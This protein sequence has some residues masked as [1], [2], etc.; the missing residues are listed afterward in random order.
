[1]GKNPAQKAKAVA[2]TTKAKEKDAAKKVKASA[3]AEAKPKK[4]AK[5]P[6]E[7]SHA[8]QEKKCQ[9]ASCKREYRAKGYCRAH[10]RKWRRGAYGKVRYKHCKDIGCLKPMVVNRHGYCEDHF[11]SYYVKGMTVAK[12]PAATPTDAKPAA[13]VKPDKAAASA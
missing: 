13:E 5:A 1:M 10:Y 7:A 11:Q 3:E 12:V 2:T 9:I 6:K 4:A 8:A